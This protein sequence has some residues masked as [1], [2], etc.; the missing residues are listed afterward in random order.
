MNL[1]R[2]ARK[3]GRERSNTVKEGWPGARAFGHI[4]TKLK[5]PKMAIAQRAEIDFRW[6]RLKMVT[7]S[8]GHP[9]YEPE[10]V[11]FDCTVLYLN[12]SRFQVVVHFF[13]RYIEG[14]KKEVFERPFMSKGRE[15]AAF[16]AF[17]EAEKRQ[18]EATAIAYAAGFKKPPAIDGA[19]QPDWVVENGEDEV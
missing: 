16:D 18:I 12:D 4:L 9:H 8:E 13:E 1:K 3:S 11:V 10:T 6:Q 2:P 15:W 5:F 19:E 14:G 7:D 17:S